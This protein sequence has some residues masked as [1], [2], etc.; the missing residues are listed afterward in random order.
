MAPDLSKTAIA[1]AVLEILTGLSAF[2]GGVAFI[3]APDGSI[4]GMSTDALE[5]SPFNDFLVPG[6]V[7]FFGVGGS[8]LLG[9]IAVLR[10]WDLAYPASFA[11]GAIVI[12]WITIQVFIINEVNFL[13]YVYWTV[14]AVTML[15]ATVLWWRERGGSGGFTLRPGPGR[16]M[17]HARR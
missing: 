7:L 16:N 5:G 17:R 1:L 9:G 3:A 13:H 6:L 2:A 10:G 4:L 12:G 11:A 15:L 8:M 14:G